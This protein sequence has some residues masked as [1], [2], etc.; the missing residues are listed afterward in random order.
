MV[1]LPFLLRDSTKL[2]VFFIIV[3]FNKFSKSTRLT[4]AAPSST[5][6]HW[7]TCY[8]HITI[9]P[10][11]SCCWRTHPVLYF[12][13]HCHKG[14]FNI[15]GIFST[16][17]QERYAQLVSKLLLNQEHLLT[18]MNEAVNAKQLMHDFYG[19]TTDYLYHLIRTADSK[20]I[21]QTFQDYAFMS[22]ILLYILQE[23]STKP[24]GNPNFKFGCK[25]ATQGRQKFKTVIEYF[26]N[27][28]QRQTEG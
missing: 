13:S 26:C 19:M 3:Y 23:F 6:F 17:F 28:L 18:I 8:S 5:L 9:L 27:K 1:Q 10:C 25:V 20:F 11:Y 16:G 7:R 22:L 12:S 21:L 24:C 14:L 4:S 2:S 15:C